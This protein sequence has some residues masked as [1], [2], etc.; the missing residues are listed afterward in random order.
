MSDII[1]TT[2]KSES[3]N[4]KLEAEQA[5]HEGAFYFRTLNTKPN[6]EIGD[7]VFYV[8][9]GY[10]RGFALVSAIATPDGNPI[11]CDTTG[12]EW[13]GKCVLWMRASS[14]KWIEPIPMRG[15]QNYRY[16]DLNYSIVGSWLDPMPE[17]KE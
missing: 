14:W 6:I 2:P 4:A 7:R 10:V 13:H 3:A 5:R 9:N 15:F 8:E 11:K 1:V 17:V 16:T 12:R